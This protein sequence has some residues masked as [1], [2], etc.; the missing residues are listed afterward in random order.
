MVAKVQVSQFIGK[1]AAIAKNAVHQANVDGNANLTKAEALKL[2]VALRDNF[3][4]Y[5]KAHGG[6]VKA[7]DFIKT[8]GAY[9]AAVAKRADTNGDGVLSA[10]E[11]KK[12]PR[13]LSDEVG[14]LSGLTIVDTPREL[15][16]HDQRLDV[17]YNRALPD[18]STLGDLVRTLD[19]QLADGNIM[20]G[21]VT[22][23]SGKLPN[24]KVTPAEL[25][26]LARSL[27]ADTLQETEGEKPR[28]LKASSGSATAALQQGA[29]FIA[30]G[31]A[32]DTTNPDNLKGVLNG[33]DDGG[34]HMVGLKEATKALGKDL[35]AAVATASV[36]DGNGFPGNNKIGLALFLNEKSGEVVG[37]YGRE[38]HT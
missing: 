15:L 35:K 26:A 8:Y 33:S 2:P 10:T 11:Q 7:E 29:E 38:G 32:F 27:L 5:Q 16:S 12:L 34:E 18:G 21:V 17:I 4:N 37:F 22:A 14:A 30:I 20:S 24:G 13:D 1:S 19:Q 9:V 28:N 31:N 3:A 36:P 6:T 25:E 23:I